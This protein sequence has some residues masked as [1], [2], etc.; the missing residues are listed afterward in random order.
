MKCIA[1]SV[2][3]R[4]F[5]IVNALTSAKMVILINLMMMQLI[6]SLVSRTAS[7]MSVMEPAMKSGARIVVRIYQGN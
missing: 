6:F 2:V 7:V 4:R 1:R 3:N 5:T